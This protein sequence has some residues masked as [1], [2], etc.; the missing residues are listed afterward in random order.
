MKNGAFKRAL[1]LTFL[2]IGI[3]VLLVFLQFSR[4]PGLS[5]KFGGLSVS[6]SYPKSERGKSGA[7]P[8]RVRLSYGGLAFELSAKS[9]VEALG[10]DGASSTLALASVAKLPNGVRIG[11]SR[12]AEL[13]AVVVKGAKE[14]FALS[15]TA[16]D[17]V[18]ALRLRLLPARSAKLDVKDGRT[19]LSS[20]GVSYDIGLGSGSIDASAG[21]LT[22][23]AGD[24]GL[25]IAKVAP[26]SAKPAAAAPPEKLVAQAPKDPAVIKAEVSAWRDKA[27]SGLSGGRFDPD[28]LAW[29]GMDGL[30]VFSE[31]ALAA[32][33]AEALARGY[34][35]EALARVRGAKERWPE[36]LGYLSAPYFGGLVKKLGD[37]AATDQPEARRLA[38]L[39]ADKSPTLLEKEG[40]FRFLVD[41]APY[42]LALDALRLVSTLDPAKLTLR[43][44]VG[45]LGSV[46]DAKALVKDEDNALRDGGAAAE[47]LLSALRKT[48]S[49]FFLAT[50]ED[51][52]SDLRL[53]LLAGNYLAAYGASASKPAMV[54]AGQSLVEGVIGLSDAQGFVPARVLARGGSLEQRTGNLA[55]ED[56]YAVAADNP[57][58]PH[59]VS[60]GRDLVP[61]LW[62]WTCSPSL[63]A[64]ASGARYVFTAR[65]LE[66]RA[67]FLALFGVKPFA[68]IQLYD[69][70]YS[71]DSE[72]ESY[73]ASGYLY[74]KAAG[75]LYLKMKHKKESEDVKLAF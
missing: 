46:L 13:K 63:S 59:A 42:Q 30:P 9:E 22:L 14:G 23:K 56:I 64:Q 62:A 39:V 54:G 17:G 31:R 18:A 66:G 60:F 52:S 19:L 75:A 74:D 72:F 41:R 34:Y 55:P 1:G 38:Q 21:L 7:T 11:L 71:P 58:Y 4:G 51:G 44:A 40:L 5:E 15:A 32:Y 24:S 37:L 73:D 35:P 43:Q 25:A 29:K 36:K 69:I 16:P 10:A 61:G 65:F 6:A 47:R 20:D 67:H 26:I 3:F 27:W 12:G 57:Y 33:L 45:L 28:K 48:S 68:N 8:E 50:E 2:Y 70:D 49:G 53:S